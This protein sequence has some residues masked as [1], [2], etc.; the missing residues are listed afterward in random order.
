MKTSSLVAV[1]GLAIAGFVGAA[2][3]SPAGD[4]A[5]TSEAPPSSGST[6]NQDVGTV[7]LELTLPEGLAIEVVD[8]SITGPNGLAAVVQSG[9]AHTKAVGLQVLI[10]NIPAGTGYRMT[11]SGASTNGGVTCTGAAPFDITPR[12]TTEVPVVLACTVASSGAHVVLVNGTS[13]NCAAW[14]NVSVSPAETTIGNSVTVTSTA[15]APAPSAIT[16]QWSAPS[17]TFGDASAANTTFTCTEAGV[18]PVTL[19]VADGPVPAGDACDPTL[20]T[21]TLAVRCD[22]TAPP[23]APALPPW[24]TSA[25]AALLAAFGGLALRRRRSPSV[26]AGLT[27]GALT[28][29][30][31][32]AGTQVGCSSAGV[33]DPGTGG[34]RRASAGDPPS[35]VGQV[36]LALTLPGGAQ[37]SSVTF[38]LRTGSATEVALVN[39][40]ANPGSVSLTESANIQLLLGGVP[41]ASG[42]TITLT[43]TTTGGAT[44]EG[45]T[46]GIDVTAGHTSEVPVLMYC[47]VP[48]ADA[49]SLAVTAVPAYC[50]T[51]NGLATNGSEAFVGQTITLTANASG[52]AP[53]SLGYTW[54]ASAPGGAT[55]GTLGA[56]RDEG[57][58]PSDAVTFQCTAPGTATIAVTVDDGPLPDGGACPSQLTTT[59]TT[60]TCDAVP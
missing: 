3:S 34:G 53:A 44:C 38:D 57:V 19:T 48:G 33:A 50:G 23:M 58:G 43:A 55:I 39:G 17:G 32:S 47:T 35:G 30:I 1:A 52:P 13:F 40:A 59:S 49:G 36:N 29:G 37:I 14:N 10:A 27:L 5:G 31:A 11:L 22:T 15:T 20:G 21:R 12:T 42:D 51:W 8:W 56:S 28:L 2:C 4:A 60:V 54:S 7:G 25:L 16:Y 41:S 9:E 45:T 6:S 26:K 24:G 46:T 18:V